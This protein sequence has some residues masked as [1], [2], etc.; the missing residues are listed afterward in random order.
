MSMEVSELASELQRQGQMLCLP[1]GDELALERFGFQSGQPV[2][3][4]FVRGRV[5]IRPRVTPEA[6]RGRLKLAA[7]DLRELAGK[8]KELARQ[9]P[10]AGGS[11][12]GA[13][14]AESLEEELVAMVECLL[15]DNL[16]PAIRRLESLDEPGPKL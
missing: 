7:R 12:E 15:A 16:E 1:V 11:I 8:M 2:T 13:D 10:A 5:E 4:R 9:L 6:A 3:I 14:G